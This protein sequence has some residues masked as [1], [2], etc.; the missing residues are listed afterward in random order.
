MV[1]F[2]VYAGGIVCR[3]LDI[4]QMAVVSVCKFVFPGT[5]VAYICTRCPF[6]AFKSSVGHCKSDISFKLKNPN[7][8]ALI[9]E[10][11][12]KGSLLIYEPI[13]FHILQRGERFARGE[14]CKTPLPIS[15]FFPLH[16]LVF[17]TEFFANRGWR[18]YLCCYL[19]RRRCGP[20]SIISHRPS[21]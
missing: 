21:L 4:R 1:S 20:E 13:D 11:A 17:L 2:H 12:M 6:D 10:L 7:I 9:L 8:L 5:N 3:K 16:D 15:S 18:N 19:W 14:P